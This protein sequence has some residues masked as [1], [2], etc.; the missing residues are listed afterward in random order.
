V[1]IERDQTVMDIA[2]GDV[3]GRDADDD[4]EVSSSAVSRAASVIRPRSKYEALKQVKSSYANKLGDIVSTMRAWK[5]FGESLGSDV[6]Q[7]YEGAF[8]EGQ[9]FNKSKRLSKRRRLIEQRTLSMPC[10]LTSFS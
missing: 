6:L 2:E 4:D 9:S 7:E 3:A 5:V 8:D 10:P 1:Q